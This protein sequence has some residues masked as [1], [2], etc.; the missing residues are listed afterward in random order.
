[1][2]GWATLLKPKVFGS[3]IGLALLSYGA[4]QIYDHIYDRGYNKRTKE[5][6]EE[7]K[8]LREE[9]QTAVDNYNRYKG[10]YDDWVLNTRDAQAK[11]LA[12]QI[13]IN[14]QLTQRN[15]ELREREP[16]V[17]IREVIKYVP[18]E[19]DARYPLPIGFLSLYAQTLQGHTA[20]ATGDAFLPGGASASFGEASP[21]TLSQFGLITSFNNAECR[22]RGELID[23]WQ[24]WYHHNQKAFEELRKVYEL[25]PIP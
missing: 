6:A 11:Q 20:A 1:M 17:T 18:A 2:I 23:D 13:E 14:R 16:E 22:L 10:E 12:D 7:M 4:Y 3:I 9:R 15:R 8:T 24:V 19:V 5:L 25:T 21:I